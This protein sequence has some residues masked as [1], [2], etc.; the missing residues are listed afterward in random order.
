VLPEEGLSWDME[1][2]AIVKGTDASEEARKLIDWSVTP[3]ANQLY[4]KG[5]AIVALPGIV[6]KL[7]HVPGDVEAMLMKN[8]FAWAAA[9]RDRILAEWSKR[10]D[11]KS[12][13]KT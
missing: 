11:G 6:G 9:N 3:E 8:D 2:S 7:E 12:E 13:P 4:A 1:A 5:Y 10:Y